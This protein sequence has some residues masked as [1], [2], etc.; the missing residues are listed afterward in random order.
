MP[1]S[2]KA[3][4]HDKELD[5]L[6]QAIV[7]Q[8]PEETEETPEVQEV[9][10]TTSEESAPSEEV[11]TPETAEEDE[12]ESKDAETSVEGEEKFTEE[13]WGVLS[14]K[15]K[16]QMTKS[17][18]KARLADDL[19]TKDKRADIMEEV[20]APLKEVSEEIKEEAYKESSKLP[21][22]DSSSQKAGQWATR[23]ME[24]IKYSERA[25]PELN[26]DMKEFD[27][28]LSGEIL[29]DF[30]AMRKSDPDF[31]L[32]EFVDRRMRSIGS[33]KEEVLKRAES[34]ADVKKQKAEEAPPTTVTTPRKVASA[35]DRIKQAKSIDDLEKMERE[36]GVSD[37]FK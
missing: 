36:L 22:G 6:E 24:D 4:K 30:R 37:R 19:L 1:S 5:K 31:R 26:P 34:A 12:S 25:Y 20:Y 16:R 13:E 17:R 29:T 15:T 14:E 8:E 2:L 9:E 23:L 11:E 18:E 21:W 27:D 10:E 7:V 32:K 33:A 35:T 3:E 28:R